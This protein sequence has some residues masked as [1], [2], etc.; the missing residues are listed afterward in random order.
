[1]VSNNQVF[2]LQTN[3]NLNPMAV[4]FSEESPQKKTRSSPPQLCDGQAVYLNEAVQ[5]TSIPVLTN[6][7]LAL[8]YE[9]IGMLGQSTLDDFSNG[10]VVLVK[11]LRKPECQKALKFTRHPPRLDLLANLKRIYNESIHVTHTI[12]LGQIYAS[13]GVYKKLNTNNG[14]VNSPQKTSQPLSVYEMELMGGDLKDL[15]KRRLSMV[16]LAVIE[17]QRIATE[18]FL[19]GKGIYISDIKDINV[20]FKKLSPEDNLNNKLLLKA[21]FWKYRI[22]NSDYYLPK[23]DY[24]IKLCDFDEWVQLPTPPSEKDYEQI[25]LERLKK[26]KKLIKQIEEFKKIPQ[27]PCTIIE[28]N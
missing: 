6:T 10:M 16:E 27:Q 12:L 5:K 26:D 20:L 11:D 19:Y 25:M 8:S 15:R 3:E 14:F 17:V 7:Q 4:Q 21:D 1:M 28:L 9:R 24:L 18:N 13:C 22:G 2:S 23:I